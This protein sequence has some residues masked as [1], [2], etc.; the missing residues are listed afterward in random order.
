MVQDFILCLLCSL[1]G[2]LDTAGQA[3]CGN[4]AATPPE[5]L[6]GSL[7]AGASDI[8]GPVG[9]LLWGGFQKLFS[10]HDTPL[11]Y[12]HRCRWILGEIY[13]RLPCVAWTW[14][15]PAGRH[16]DTLLVVA[17]RRGARC[18]TLVKVVTPKGI[19]WSEIAFEKIK[20]WVLE[21]NF[22]ILSILKQLWL[23]SHVFVFMVFHTT[24]VCLTVWLPW[25]FTT[26]MIIWAQAIKQN[27]TTAPTGTFLRGQLIADS[28]SSE[29][30]QANLVGP[31]TVEGHQLDLGMDSRSDVWY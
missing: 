17:D 16:R 20:N 19:R 21:F 8:Y 14:R 24:W 22:N 12:S 18:S 30:N 4:L 15:I 26:V 25:W 7:V 29:W 2:F 1:S 5:A 27:E 9:K 3:F 28:Q 23:F 31:F 6:R 13:S 11:P 10:S